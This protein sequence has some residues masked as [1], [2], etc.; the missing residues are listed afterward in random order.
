MTIT[1]DYELKTKFRKFCQDKNL[2]MSSEI[3]RLV[4]EEMEE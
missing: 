4:R 1:I 2:M 3:E